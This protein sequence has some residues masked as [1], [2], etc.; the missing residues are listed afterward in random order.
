M[1]K[2]MLLRSTCDW[3]LD[4]I[5]VHTIDAFLA[6]TG[7]S[8]AHIEPLSLD[9]YLSYSDW[10]LAQ[11][12]L[13]PHPGRV[14]RLDANGAA[15]VATLDTGEELC[16]RSVVVA[17]GLRYFANVPAELKSVLPRGSF[18]HTCELVDLRRLH[19]CRCL[20]VGGRQSAFEWAAL[21]R[22]AGATAVH[23]C[24]RH[25]TPEFAT[26]DWSWI[27]PLVK[28]TRTDPTWYRNLPDGEKLWHGLEQRD[29][30]PELDESLQTSHR[31]LFITGQPAVRDFGPFFGFTVAVGVSA[32]QIGQALLSS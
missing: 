3:H 10:F 16:A 13:R 31:G 23:I 26:S 21:S 9:F 30:F 2:G 20:I 22:E 24:Y 15:Y 25:D 32:E 6:V 4:P 19:D 17:V 28:R 12:S 14:R 29:A 18:A 27:P 7:R 5:G 8:C 11:K 1:P